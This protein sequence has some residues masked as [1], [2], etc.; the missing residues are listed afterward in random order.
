MS[1]NSMLRNFRKNPLLRRGGLS[2]EDLAQADPFIREALI[3]NKRQG[4]L[5]AV[6]ARWI[7]LGVVAIWLPFFNFRWEVLYYEAAV[8]ILPSS[9]R[10][11]S[12]P[13]KLQ[14]PGE[15]SC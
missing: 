13:A 3:E 15:N 11:S 2:D 10:R 8:V 7:A 5:L 4:L 14:P 1:S 6:R 12:V 9:V